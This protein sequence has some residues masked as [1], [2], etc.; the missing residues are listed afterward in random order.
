MPDKSDS[1]GSK[2]GARGVRM[3]QWFIGGCAIVF[4][5]ALFSI[6]MYYIVPSGDAVIGCKL[7]TY[8]EVEF[9][10]AIRELLFGY[11]LGPASGNHWAVFVAVAQHLLLSLAGGVIG[12]ATGAVVRRARRPRP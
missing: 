3:W 2:Q 4:V 5:G 6:N 12:L 8:Y 7:W 9:P 11:T 1:A 10:R